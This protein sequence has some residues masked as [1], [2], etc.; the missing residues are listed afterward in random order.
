MPQ[1]SQPCPQNPTSLSIITDR[2]CLTP[3][4]GDNNL[5]LSLGIFSPTVQC[6]G[7]FGHEWSSCRDI[8]GDM[9]ASGNRLVFGPRG[10]PGVQQGLPV[11]IDSCKCAESGIFLDPVQ[12]SSLLSPSLVLTSLPSFSSQCGMLTS[13]PSIGLADNKCVAKTFTTGKTDVSTWYRI[14]EAMTALFSVCVRAGKGG[15][16]RGIGKSPFSSSFRRSLVCT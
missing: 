5:A 10:L 14:W 9:P 1:G 15:V 4:G 12:F 16:S 3:Q 6:R 11:A 2:P 7:A 13:A 8:L